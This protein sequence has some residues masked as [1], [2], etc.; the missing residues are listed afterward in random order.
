[1]GCLVQIYQAPSEKKAR[2]LAREYE[3][4]NGVTT[5]IAKGEGH[6]TYREPRLRTWTGPIK[7]HDRSR[8][9]KPWSRRELGLTG[10]VV[11]HFKSPS[12]TKAFLYW[13][14]PGSRL[15]L[16]MGTITLVPIDHPSANGNYDSRAQAEVAVKRFLEWT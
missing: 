8:S 12:G 7:Q 6:K 9:K 4:K 10:S 14:G 2:Q 3:R 5:R 1:V 15:F 16:G 13:R 11:W